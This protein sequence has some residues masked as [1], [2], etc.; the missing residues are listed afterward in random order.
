MPEQRHDEH[1]LWIEFLEGEWLEVAPFL[2]AKGFKE[3]ASKFGGALEKI[4]LGWKDKKAKI[5][6]EQAEKAE[7][8]FKRDLEK[9]MTL[10]L[11]NASNAEVKIINDF[12]RQVINDQKLSNAK[13]KIDV[14]KFFR[15]CLGKPTEINKS[16]SQHK[17]ATI[18]EDEQG[19]IDEVF[20][21]NQDDK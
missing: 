20:D 4:T 16:F 5:K 6:K 21:L 15:L 17:I 2:R 1:A 12:A 14:A 10:A 18:S 3:N 19:E 11:R 7:A 13:D 9:K 8:N